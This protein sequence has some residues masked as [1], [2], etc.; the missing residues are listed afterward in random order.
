MERKGKTER[1]NGDKR[2]EYNENQEKVRVER[3]E[4][5][6]VTKSSGGKS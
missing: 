2:E 5:E 4:G 1:Q 6:R 3:R